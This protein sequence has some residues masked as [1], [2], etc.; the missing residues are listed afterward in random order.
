MENKVKEELKL[1]IRLQNIDLEL[2]E[3]ERFR[4]QYPEI[5]KKLEKRIEEDRRKFTQ[6]SERL[7][8]L[9]RERRQKEKELEIEMQRIKKAEDKL[10][11]VKTNKEYQSALKEIEMLKQ[12]NSA[13]EDEILLLMDEID[14]LNAELKLRE[15]ELAEK[16][17]GYQEEK[18]RL[19]EKSR[20]L[21]KI[22]EEKKILRE[23]VVNKLES[24]LLRQYLMVSEKRNGLA[25]VKVSNE[26]CSGCSMHI[27]P[28]VYNEVLKST[29]I[30]TCPNC[31]RIL[32]V[33]IPDNSV[34]KI[35]TDVDTLNPLR[36]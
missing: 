4:Q 2:S 21:E 22:S 29:Q 31:N 7:E 5:L 20:K 30:I 36:V 10:D 23:E 19:E 28:Q 26:T 9:Q 8:N 3:S 15:K 11:A 35:Y 24:K 16:I 34:N 14:T 17:R 27:P 1:L 6:A 18:K 12:M 32:Y 13:K 25:V 33:E